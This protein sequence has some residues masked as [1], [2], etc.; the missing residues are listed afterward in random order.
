LKQSLF[1]RLIYPLLLFKKHPYACDYSPYVA[2]SA[3]ELRRVTHLVSRAY[4]CG[5]EVVDAVGLEKRGRGFY[6]A[7][8]S[9]AGKYK[10]E[11]RKQ[12]L[13]LDELEKHFSRVGLPFPNSR[14]LISFDNVDILRFQHFLD[15]AGKPLEYRLGEVKSKELSEA[16]NRYQLYNSCWREKE[17]SPV[18]RLQLIKE[19]F[20]WRSLNERRKILKKEGI[21][22]EEMSKTMEKRICLDRK[23]TRRILP[24]L[25]VHVALSSFLH[26]G[27]G[28]IARP[29]YT[30]IARGVDEMGRIY[31]KKNRQEKQIHN[32]LT[33]GLSVV[34]KSLGGLLP[35]L[36]FWAYA[37]N[38]IG[39]ESYRYL[40]FDTLSFNLSR[41]GLDQ[42]ILSGVGNKIVK[43]LLRRLLG[44]DERLS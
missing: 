44:S 24:H 23:L 31:N 43:K 1:A 39:Q 22:D 27:L 4:G 35:P 21:I 14:H 42:R 11:N 9:E 28:S 36:S 19:A 37:S 5:A 10:P 34:P 15:L 38:I 20:G 6:A 7:Y 26:G 17:N 2:A 29:A 40:L 16:W 3:F 33:L 41:V 25:L 12:R 32:L 13:G 18:R 8:V 30:A